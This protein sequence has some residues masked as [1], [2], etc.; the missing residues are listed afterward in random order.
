MVAKLTTRWGAIW[1]SAMPFSTLMIAVERPPLAFKV[2]ATG[3]ALAQALKAQVI[4]VHVN[5]PALLY[6]SDSSLSPTQLES[7]MT[8]AA[9]KLLQELITLYA[10]DSTPLTFVFEGD[11]EHEILKA[12]NEIKPDLLVIGTQ[13][14]KPWKE[15]LLGSVSE[16]IMRHSI[17]PV[18]LIRASD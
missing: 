9:E 6:S 13:G 12:M 17:C 8:Q 4:L 7:Q 10:K 1:S 18:M 11:T 15:L 2:A 14:K 3:F 16:D 5:P